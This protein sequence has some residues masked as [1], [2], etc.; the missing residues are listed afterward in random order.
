MNWSCFASPIHTVHR[1]QNPL[2]GS[3]N[4]MVLY[5]DPCTLQVLLTYFSSTPHQISIKD[6]RS[7]INDHGTNIKDEISK[8][9]ALWTDPC[10][11]EAL[12][13]QCSSTPECFERFQYTSGS[14]NWSQYSESIH[15][16]KVYLNPF[17]IVI[18]TK[19]NRNS[20]FFRKTQFLSWPF[21]NHSYN[22][23]RKHK[24]E[25]LYIIFI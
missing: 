2:N 14:M 17:W 6:Q 4:R 22:C 5:T 9:K 20:S 10:T 11:L 15:A 7:K 19:C 3:I 23:F 16:G 25:S 1:H 8:I 18:D 12:L 21:I 13:T 24:K